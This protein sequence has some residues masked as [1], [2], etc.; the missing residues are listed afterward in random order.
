MK[1]TIFFTFGKNNL[2]N[3][4]FILEYNI[5]LMDKR[6]KL[7]GKIHNDPIEMYLYIIRIMLGM[8]TALSAELFC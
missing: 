8:N 7:L 6:D 4:K 3:E 5:K 2:D 1:N